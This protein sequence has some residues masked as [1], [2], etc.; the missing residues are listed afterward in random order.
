MIMSAS[1]DFGTDYI[2]FLDQD[3]A[4][5]W[6]FSLKVYPKKEFGLKKVVLLDFFNMAPGF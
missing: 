6:N 1:L 4:G 5:I 2:K 3:W